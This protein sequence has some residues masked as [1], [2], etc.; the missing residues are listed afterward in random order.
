MD[1]F[2]NALLSSNRNPEIPEED[3]WYAPLLGDWDFE[4]SDPQGRR[5]KGEWF[6]R[7]VLDGMAIEDLFICPSRATRDVNPQPDGE[8]GVAIRMY[9]KQRRCYNMTY[10]C[11]RYTTHLEVRKE[12]GKITCTCLEDKTNKWFFDEITDHTFH[13]QNITVLANEKWHVNCE[14][15]AHR[16]NNR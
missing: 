8:Y 14:V 5:V 6:F 13:W 3:D 7:R 16:K 9:D 1:E 12:N 10:S 2:V 11:S 15:H 4:F